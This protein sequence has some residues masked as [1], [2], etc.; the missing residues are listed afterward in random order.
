MEEYLHPPAALIA[1]I[2]EE[3]LEVGRDPKSK[4][5]HIAAIGRIF[6]SRYLMTQ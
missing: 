4:P 1:Q 6:K 3:K 5:F 2:P